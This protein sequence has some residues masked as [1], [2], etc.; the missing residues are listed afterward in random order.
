MLVVL[1]QTCPCSELDSPTGNQVHIYWSKRTPNNIIMLTL[2]LHLC[3]RFS[4]LYLVSKQPPPTYHTAAILA[5]KLVSKQPPLT[6]HTAAILAAK[7]VSKQPPITYHTA[8]I[9]AAK[10]V[11]KQ[12]PLTY[13]TAA[14]LAAKLPK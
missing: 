10:L 14:I 3:N 8:A 2:T 6:Y 9:L 11:S 4:T 5:A 1:R 12:P 13:H 7:L